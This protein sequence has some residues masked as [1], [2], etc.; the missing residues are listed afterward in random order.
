[1]IA[2]R[3]TFGDA[4]VCTSLMKCLHVDTV[5]EPCSCFLA[6][7][8]NQ[9]SLV[10]C[11]YRVLSQVLSEAMYKNISITVYQAQNDNTIKLCTMY[12]FKDLYGVCHVGCTEW[13]HHQTAQHVHILRLV[14]SVS[15]WVQVQWVTDSK[16]SSRDIGQQICGRHCLMRCCSLLTHQILRHM[17]GCW[18]C[19]NSI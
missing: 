3:N 9:V 12:T 13:Q 7:M 1:M 14:L 5:V 19:F 8:C 17:I 11:S 16:P 10:L 6:G 15:C 2:C 18:L 4:L